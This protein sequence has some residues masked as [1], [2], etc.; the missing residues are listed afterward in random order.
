M[1]EDDGLILGELLCARLCHDLAGAIGAVGTGVEL[2]GDEGDGSGDGSEA[3]ALLAGSAQAAIHR[4]K[5]LRLALGG[6]GGALPMA[7]L[8]DVAGNFLAAS[9]TGGS[10]IALEWGEGDPAAKWDAEAAKLLLNL[11]LLARDSLPRGGVV[12]VEVAAGEKVFARVEARGRG[13]QPT[14]AATAL[15]AT[16]LSGLGPR[17]AQGYYAAKLAK[18]LGWAIN[19]ED[20]HDSMIFVATKS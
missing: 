16:D 8:R 2:L 14:G 6:G 11:I 20:S 19:Y 13:A 4:F 12:R 5:F 18:R 9:G 10:A 15:K 7:Q 17:G 1:S 3:F